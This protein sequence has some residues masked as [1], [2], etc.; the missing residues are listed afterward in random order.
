ML[1]PS[2]H[3]AN[4]PAAV[5]C[6]RCRTNL[7]R[8]AEA[9]LLAGRYEVRSCLGKGGMGIV[10]KAYDRVLE[11]TVAIK[12]LLRQE[13]AGSSAGRRFRSEIKLARKV[14]HRNVCRIH[15]YGEDGGAP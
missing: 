3:A 10:Y 14:T 9:L 12:V 1:C 2:C 11:E 6:V 13:A 15:D 5:T 4:D 8:T 7:P